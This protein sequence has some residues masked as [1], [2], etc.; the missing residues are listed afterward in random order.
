MF[1]IFSIHW[2]Y[3]FVA[4]QHERAPRSC[5]PNSHLSAG[6]IATHTDPKGFSSIHQIPLHHPHNRLFL[7]MPIHLPTAF[8][9]SLDS[10]L[11]RHYSH[12]NAF[13]PSVFDS[14]H[15]A[16]SNGSLLAPPP[17]P[18]APP[19]LPPPSLIPADTP[20]IEPSLESRE[21]I[22]T[23][24]FHA[25]NAFKSLPTKNDS[26]SVQTSPFHIPGTFSMPAKSVKDAN[27]KEDEVSSSEEILTLHNLP[28]SSTLA[29]QNDQD[30]IFES[31]AKLL[32]L[33]VKWVR[34]IPSFNQLSAIDQNVL[35]E[36]C[37]AELFIIMS[38]Q[39]GLPIGSK[40]H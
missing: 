24:T 19:S 29:T 34:S 14:L 12:F 6:L 37:W 5:I 22:L 18:P 11:S 38:A 27:G 26:G 17:P 25:P 30:I 4:V 32:I 1:F 39:Y 3:A 21:N 28:N 7:P 2:L 23:H 13:H 16:A 40:S 8:S 35:L 10:Q 33:T 31:A 15:F 9:S 20:S 36:E